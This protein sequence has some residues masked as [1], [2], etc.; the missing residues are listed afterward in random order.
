MS[1]K[2]FLVQVKLAQCSYSWQS[3]SVLHIVAGV[4]QVPEMHCCPVAHAFPTLPQFLLSFIRLA[5]QPFAQFP[6][7]FA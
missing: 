6:S 3:A 1:A 2:S 7:R 5:S 4:W